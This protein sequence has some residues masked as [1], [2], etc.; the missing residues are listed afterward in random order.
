MN[1]FDKRLTELEKKNTEDK[2]IKWIVEVVNSNKE[3]VERYHFEPNKN[4]RLNNAKG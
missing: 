3:V 2:S 1:S 4:L